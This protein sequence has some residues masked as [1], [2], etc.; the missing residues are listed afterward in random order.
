LGAQVTLILL[1]P[2]SNELVTPLGA[3]IPLTTQTSRH[4]GGFEPLW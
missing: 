1:L 4:R 2:G 3:A